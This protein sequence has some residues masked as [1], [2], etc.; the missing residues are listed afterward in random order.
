[1]KTFEHINAMTVQEACALLSKYKG[2][3]VLNAGGT[4]LLGVLKNGILLD[5]PE[6]VINIKTISGLDYIRENNGVLKIGA[7]AKLSD[8]AQSPLLKERYGA[9]AMAAHSVATPHI[10]NAAT[11]GG[12]LCQ[13][14]RC[15]YY[16]YPRHIGGPINCLR[17]GSGPCLA[18]R[19]DNRYHAIMDGKKCFAVCPSDTAIALAALNGQIILTG[20]EGQRKMAVVDFFSPLG[21]RLKSYEMITEV[22]IPMVT[23][24][25]KQTFLKFTLREPVDFALVSVAMVITVKEGICTDARIALG[26]VAPGPI[27]AK[28]AEDVIKGRFLDED[29]AAEAGALAVAGARPLSHNEYKVEIAKTLVKRAILA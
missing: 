16:R 23:D 21:N 19:G 8:M 2:K 1:M 12:N 3:A 5:Y 15:W 22:E 4:D 17:K 11:I 7:L 13:D 27:R 18:V 6:A 14:I 29:A 26:A 10:R 9:L 20:P 24:P 25:A 28:H